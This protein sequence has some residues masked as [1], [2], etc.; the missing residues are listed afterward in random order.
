[1]NSMYE[2]ETWELVKL[3]DDRKASGSKWTYKIKRDACGKIT[4]SKARLVAQGFS[5]KFGI[6]YEEVF[7]PVARTTTFKVLLAVAS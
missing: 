7:A 6:D 5:Q 3:P 4:R 2:N 1:M